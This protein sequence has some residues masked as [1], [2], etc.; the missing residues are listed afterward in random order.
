MRVTIGGTILGHGQREGGEKES[1]ILQEIM[2]RKGVLQRSE[3]P[4]MIGIT[5]MI[6][7]RGKG[8]ERESVQGQLITKRKDVLQGREMKVLIGVAGKLQGPVQ[9]KGGEKDTALSQKITKR[10]VMQGRKMFDIDII[11]QVQGEGK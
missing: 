9:G 2:N 6:L 10:K 1:T 8:G 3:L 4:V 5:D 11:D 7:D